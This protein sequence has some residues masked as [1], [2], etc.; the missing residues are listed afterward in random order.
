MSDRFVLDNSIAIRWVLPDRE[1]H[2][3][4]KQIIKL[5]VVGD[6][7]VVAPKNMI[8]EFCGA[9]TKAYR[10]RRKSAREA[11]R[12]IRSFME[13]PIHYIESQE[14]IERATSLS[15]DFRKNF[16]DMYYFSV[17]ESEG[18]AVC[19]ADEKSVSGLGEGFPCK[20]VLLED[21]FKSTWR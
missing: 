16:Y 7:H 21:F 17:A 19:T 14:L 8:Y 11:L 4:A 3:L 10:K 13:L 6:I 2:N 1:G 12:A 15:M 20:Y 18:L 9:V 5:L